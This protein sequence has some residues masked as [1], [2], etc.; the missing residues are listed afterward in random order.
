MRRCSHW[1]Q[2]NLLKVTLIRINADSY[3]CENCDVIWHHHADA[4]G[5][6]GAMTDSILAW[7]GYAA[8][9][10]DA[11]MTVHGFVDWPEQKKYHAPY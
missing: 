8:D 10:R 2:G 5:A 4:G 1:K 9:E 11:A 7:L 3:I 6:K